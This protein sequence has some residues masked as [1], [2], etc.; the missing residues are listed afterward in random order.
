MA[1]AKTVKF[2][3]RAGKVGLKNLGNTCFMNA[4]L[5]CLSH[6]EPLVA[7]FL[8]GD[9]RKEL[10]PTNPLSCKGE[11]AQTFADLLRALWQSEQ[12]AY[13]PR[14]FRKMLRRIAPHLFDGDEQQDVQEFLAFCI[15][16]LHED[17]NRIEG[18]PPPCSEKQQKEDERLGERKGDDFASAL[19]WLRHLERGKSFLVD[20]MQGQLRSSLTCLKCGQESR[21]F[22][23]FLYLSLPVEKGMTQV[24]DAIGKYLEAE[25]LTGSERWH[26]K[27]CKTKVNARKKIDVWKLPP[28][29]VL[30][31]KRF[32]FDP[33]SGEFVKTDN[34]LGMKL[35][36]L[37]LSEFCSSPQRDGATYN[38]VGVANH[39]G[40]YGS[41]HYTATCKVPGKKGAEAW[42]HFCDTTVKAYDGRNVV[43]RDSYVI[44]LVRNQSK[45]ELASMGVPARPK[46]SANLLERMSMPLRRQTLQ[47][48]QNWP[49]AKEAVEAV[50]QATGHAVSAS[51]VASPLRKRGRSSCGGSKEVPILIGDETP[52]SAA[53]RRRLSSASGSGSPKNGSPKK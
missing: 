43:T 30:H 16:G 17:L 50:L 41:G 15:D 38:V 1:S 46:A 7:Y 8:N 12:A 23:P 52:T 33:K 32:E 22:D 11:L 24:S 39:T 10:N 5:Q 21:R 14:T 37:D 35:S 48:P 31:L 28:V 34:R 44:F 3:K 51:S 53:K 19:A 27:R 9:F 40:E 45:R 20:L 26:C 13:D 42:H 25:E 2:S 4:G 6:I 18:K 49:H 47:S 29:L 36:S